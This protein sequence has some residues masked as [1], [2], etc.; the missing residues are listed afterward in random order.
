MRIF[1]IY[2]VDGTSARWN[3]PSSQMGQMCG[4]PLPSWVTR[5]KKCH[6][7]V[8]HSFFSVNKSS[9]LRVFRGRIEIMFVKCW[10][11]GL[12]YINRGYYYIW[13]LISTMS[14][15]KVAANQD[16]HYCHWCKLRRQHLE[17][18][19]S[20]LSLSLSFSFIFNIPHYQKPVRLL[21]VT[22]TINTLKISGMPGWL[23][24]KIHLFSPMHSLENAWERA[25]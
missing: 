23:L 6:L 17:K 5:N 9:F 8:L 24:S 10:G 7:S 3:N 4:K 15:T 1:L 14:F 11:Q 20:F 16:A 19:R 25:N 2:F 13:E 22:Y 18:N 21:L 12:S